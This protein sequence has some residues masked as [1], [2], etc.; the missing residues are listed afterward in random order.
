MKT[1]SAIRVL[2]YIYIIEEG[3]KS[4]GVLVIYLAIFKF[5]EKVVTPL[6]NN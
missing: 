4:E 5:R 6:I 2:K 3:R 1:S